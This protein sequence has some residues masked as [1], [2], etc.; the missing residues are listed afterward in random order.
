MLALIPSL[1]RCR[2]GASDWIGRMTDWSQLTHAYGP[3]DDVPALLELAEA[4]PRNP[5]WNE[6][7]SRLCHQGTV[8]PASYAALPAL[9]RMARK[10]P[11]ADRTTPLYLSGAIVASIDQPYTDVDPYTE[12]AT[13]IAELI[14]LTQE[15]LKNP[16]L[17]GDPGTWV[18]LMGTLLSL[19]GVEVWGEQLDGLNNEEYEVPCPR[20][21]DENFIVFGGYGYF[22]TAD[23][24][25]MKHPEA[26]RNPLLPSDPSALRGLAERLHARA[27]ADG[28]QQLAR[29]LTY[30]F[31]N[32]RCVQCD[33]LFSV[34]AAV[35]TRWG[36]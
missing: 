35:T 20:C 4:D 18:Q 16:R 31:G 24:M 3:A 22:S 36:A 30:V 13:E 6:L 1:S 12:H 17:S 15:T 29:Q 21:E 33:E 27:L 11:A 14:A 9:A 25:Y 26:H 2:I 10:W 19:E 23:S 34:E 28:H 5:A 7:W 8:Y 32:A